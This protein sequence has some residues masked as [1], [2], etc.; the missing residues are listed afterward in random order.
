[1]SNNTPMNT[2]SNTYVIAI[3][4]TSRSATLLNNDVNWPNL[5][6]T[7]LSDK[8]AF[9]VTGLDTAP[10]AV[11]PTSATA[12]KEGKVIPGGAVVTFGKVPGHQYVSAIQ[13]ASGTGNLYI[14]SGQGE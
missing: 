11:F 7:N 3:D 12:P 5:V 8:A 4:N 6:I 9:V 14:S 1:M 10:T 13:L 2:N